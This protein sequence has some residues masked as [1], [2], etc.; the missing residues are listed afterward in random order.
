M[1]GGMQWQVNESRDVGGTSEGNWRKISIAL[2]DP[3]RPISMSEIALV[4]AAEAKSL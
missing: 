2:I 4:A 3:G 1:L